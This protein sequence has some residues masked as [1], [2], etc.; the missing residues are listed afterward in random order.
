MSDQEKSL[1]Q[2]AEEQSIHP[3][4]HLSD[5]LG[6]GAS[7]WETDTEFEAFLSTMEENDNKAGR[8]K[9]K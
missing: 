5:V 2:L 3:L 9:N 1:K 6:G 4:Q 8:K 7:L